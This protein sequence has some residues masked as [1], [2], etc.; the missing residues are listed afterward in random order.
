MCDGLQPIVGV[1]LP[2]DVMELIPQSLKR[3]IKMAGNFRRVLA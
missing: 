2:I 3:D 1:Q